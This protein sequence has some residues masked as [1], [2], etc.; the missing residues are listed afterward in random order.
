MS[1][2]YILGA[3]AME[4]VAGY[5][6]FQIYGEHVGGF[7][8][9]GLIVTNCHFDQV[10]FNDITFTSCNFS[11][12]SFESATL[13]D[14]TFSGC[15]LSYCDFSNTELINVLFENCNVSNLQF[16][17]A[18][19]EFGGFMNCTGEID[20]TNADVKS[21]NFSMCDLEDTSLFDTH[22]R[23]VVF[24]KCNL[25]NCRVSS[26]TSLSG[27]RLVSCD[28]TDFRIT[29]C[30]RTDFFMSNSTYRPYTSVSP[31]ILSKLRDLVKQETYTLDYSCHLFCSSIEEFNQVGNRQ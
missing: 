31:G 17:D 6:S 13:E 4:A 24:T 2:P 29:R 20:L 19:I 12:A 14:V 28:I 10:T 9:E 30:R 1:A 5:D 16:T 27:V 11:A 23:D 8:T 15:D 21:Y 18:V 7:K 25:T 26:L 3:E 22:L